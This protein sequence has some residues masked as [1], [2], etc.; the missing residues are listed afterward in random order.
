VATALD[1]VDEF[2]LAVSGPFVDERSA[3]ILRVALRS[4]EAVHFWLVTDPGSAT[5]VT[6]GEQVGP[7]GPAR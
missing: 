4:V 2:R 1:R 7:G 6:E 5:P 3:E